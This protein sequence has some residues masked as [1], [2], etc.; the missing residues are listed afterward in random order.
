MRTD[1]E[2]RKR[3]VTD[4]EVGKQGLLKRSQ[5]GPFEDAV[6]S[7]PQAALKSPSEYVR[8]VDV[9]ARMSADVRADGRWA[10]CMVICTGIS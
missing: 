2:K 8:M 9:R 10:G 3:E 1:N 4:N 6:E 5:V 7:N